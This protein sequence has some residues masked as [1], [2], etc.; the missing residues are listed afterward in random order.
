MQICSFLSRYFPPVVRSA[1]FTD[2][3]ET[4]FAG[5]P[6]IG[7]TST[8]N[9]DMQIFPPTNHTSSSESEEF[10]KGHEVASR[11]LFF[12]V[13]CGKNERSPQR[14]FFLPCLFSLYHTA[15]MRVIQRT[16]GVA[17][18]GARGFAT[19]A[20]RTYSAL[21][22]ACLLLFLWETTTAVFLHSSIMPLHAFNTFLTRPSPPTSP[23][24]LQSR[25]VSP[26]PPTSPRLPSP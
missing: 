14:N 9:E 8:M 3:P 5:W 12:S 13:F 1:F 10:Q 26:P 6:A 20:Q 7:T 15:K 24:T 16:A 18:S 2:L 21:T 25:P 11:L 22:S 4:S 23:N 17:R 19:E